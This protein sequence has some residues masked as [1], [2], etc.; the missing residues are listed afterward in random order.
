MSRPA[1]RRDAR[2]NRNHSALRRI[3]RDR[4]EV[5]CLRGFELRQITCSFRCDVAKSIKDNERNFAKWGNVLPVKV[6]LMSS[7]NPGQPLAAS[8]YLSYIQGTGGEIITG[9]E[10]IT[11]SVSAAD[12]GNV[13]RLND[14]FYIYNFSTKPLTAGKDYTLRVR[15]GSATGPI[16]LTAVLNLK[17]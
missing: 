6:S 15:Y 2:R 8:L 13:M 3:F 7:C 16:L 12:T 11:T 9:T 1:A 4:V 14:S 10:E 5:R 17:K